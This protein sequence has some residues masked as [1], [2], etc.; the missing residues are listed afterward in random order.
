MKDDLI[1]LLADLHLG[2]L[3]L[4]TYHLFQCSSDP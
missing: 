1:K 3:Q 4:G 2:N